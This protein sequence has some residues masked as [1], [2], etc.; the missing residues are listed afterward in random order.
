M[1]CCPGHPRPW[2][3]RSMSDCCSQRLLRMASNAA[4]AGINSAHSIVR[5]CKQTLAKHSYAPTTTGG[6]ASKTWRAKRGIVEKVS[7]SWGPE[8][9]VREFRHLCETLANM[10]ARCCERHNT[11]IRVA[12]LFRFE[13][14]DT[15]VL[16]NC[17][18]VDDSW[19]CY[20]VH[21]C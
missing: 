16:E 11:S 1:Q 7:T 9:N 6:K 18:S 20:R 17:G 14:C 5:L 4:S 2:L 13:V 3:P 15:V 8:R 19:I 10:S 12:L 21:G